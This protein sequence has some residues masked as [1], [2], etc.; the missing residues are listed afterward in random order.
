[1]SA[2][3]PSGFDREAQRRRIDEM[4]PEQVPIEGGQAKRPV[5][6]FWANVVSTV[7]TLLPIRVRTAFGFAL[8]FAFNQSGASLRLLASWLSRA[9]TNVSIFAVYFLVLGPTSFVARLLGHDYLRLR[10]VDG[11]MWTDKEPADET[12]AR[13][14]RQ[15]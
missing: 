6:L 5:S 15:Y 10:D 14:S 8:N 7:A 2:S 13:F 1:M 3:D 9:V 4:Q 11:S 12:E